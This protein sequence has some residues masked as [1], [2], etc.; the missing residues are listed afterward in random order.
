MIGLIVLL[1]IATIALFAIAYNTEEVG[2]AV[3][4]LICAVFLVTIL[5]I[6]PKP[7]YLH[8]VEA[9]KE[10]MLEARGYC[11]IEQRDAVD[12]VIHEIED[13]ETK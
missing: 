7:A 9:A 4:G 11:K 6:T 12:K 10:R 1:L 5:V 2:Y 8:Q 13:L 3:A